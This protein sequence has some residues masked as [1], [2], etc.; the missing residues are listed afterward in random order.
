MIYYCKRNGRPCIGGSFDGEDGWDIDCGFNPAGCPFQER[1]E[2]KEVIKEVE[3]KLK[4]GKKIYCMLF[5]LKFYSG[6]MANGK[7]FYHYH[8]T[9][10]QEILELKIKE[11]KWPS[12]YFE[13]MAA[14][15]EMP[16]EVHVQHYGWIADQ[17]QDFDV[18]Y[19]SYELT[20]EEFEKILKSL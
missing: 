11:E 14:F 2:E 8:K 15:S 9:E 20:S 19:K 17:K 5:V 1:N 13:T 6:K 4:K 7:T 18:S 12:A 3:E 10:K 16:F